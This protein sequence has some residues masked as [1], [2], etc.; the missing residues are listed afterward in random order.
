MFYQD[1]F[2][3]GYTRAEK[4]KKYQERNCIGALIEEELAFDAADIMRFGKDVWVRRSQTANYKGI[5]WLRR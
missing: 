4:L 5:Q 1:F 2:R 3:K